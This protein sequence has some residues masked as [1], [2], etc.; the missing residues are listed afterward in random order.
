MNLDKNYQ[1]YI[2]TSRGKLFFDIDN[3]NNIVNENVVRKYLERSLQKVEVI[4]HQKKNYYVRSL[5]IKQE[6]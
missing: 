1:N 3:D 2:Q 5:E 6:M 4:L